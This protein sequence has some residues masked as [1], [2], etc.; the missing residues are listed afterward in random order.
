ML[1]QFR[2]KDD[3]KAA[4]IEATKAY[5]QYVEEPK[6]SQR[7]CRFDMELELF[8]K[9]IRIEEYPSIRWRIVYTPNHH[10][11]IIADI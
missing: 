4:R 11:N 7:R 8:I 2:I 5:K 1:F 9:I 3:I 10:Q 6:T